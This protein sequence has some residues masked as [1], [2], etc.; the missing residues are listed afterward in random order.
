MKWFVPEDGYGD[1]EEDDHDS[2]EE[3][4]HGELAGVEAGRRLTRHLRELL[5]W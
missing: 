1:Q 4:K 3:P 5:Q 2:V